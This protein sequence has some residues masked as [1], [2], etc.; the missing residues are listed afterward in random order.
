MCICVDAYMGIWVKRLSPAS[1]ALQP[2]IASQVYVKM[3]GR[4]IAPSSS[5]P[6]HFLRLTS[7]RP[8]GTG[9]AIY[10]CKYGDQ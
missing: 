4:F 5:Y 6:S 9:V 1:T 3:C 2:V 8:Q 7:H 10:A